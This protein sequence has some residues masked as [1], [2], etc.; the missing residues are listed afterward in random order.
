[1][2]RSDDSRVWVPSYMTC[3]MQQE[4]EKINTRTIVG[5]QIICN[6]LSYFSKC[7]L[8]SPSKNVFFLK[9]FLKKM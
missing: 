2:S 5:L 4:Y 9:D 1:M 6:S 7:M 8:F 3:L